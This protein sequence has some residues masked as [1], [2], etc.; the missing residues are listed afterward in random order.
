MV[1]KPTYVFNMVV[2][3]T[4]LITCVLLIACA[5]IADATV[6]EAIGMTDGPLL[7]IFMIVP[8]AVLANL[9]Y[10]GGWIGELLVRG[11]GKLETGTVFALKAFRGGVVF[12]V[13]VTLLPAVLCWGAF[14][15]ALLSGQK[16]GPPGE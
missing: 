10:T 7:G 1:G 6:G 11:V 13:F 12:S 2:G 9:F 15:V 8:Y 3:C 4:G 16:H 14:A 5:F